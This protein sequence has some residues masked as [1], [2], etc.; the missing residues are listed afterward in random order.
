MSIPLEV[1]LRISS[2]TLTSVDGEKQRVN[3]QE[4]RFIKQITVAAV[5]KAGEI[6][7]LSVRSGNTF[8]AVVNNTRWDDSK[9]LFIA[10]CGAKL[11]GA[12]Y[13]QLVA[14]PDWTSRNLL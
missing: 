5:P 10:F 12:N 2:L 11:S 9:D 7:T 14:D 3:N 4:V 8:D 13:Q 1:N 6:F